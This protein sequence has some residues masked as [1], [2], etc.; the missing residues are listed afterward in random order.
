MPHSD[1]SVACRRKTGRPLGIA[2]LAGGYWASAHFGLS[3]ATF[4]RSVTLVWPST[5]IA[6]VALTLG[7]FDLWPGVALGALA[8][9]ALTPGVPLWAA[10]AMALGNTLEALIG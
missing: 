1:H 10:T 7:G 9:N 5:G 8:V 3:F 6:L 2:L 4:G